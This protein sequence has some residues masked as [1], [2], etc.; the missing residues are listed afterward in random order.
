[1]GPPSASEES[2]FGLIQSDLAGLTL[3]PVIL[4]LDLVPFT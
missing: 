2:E 1:M 4:S 3:I